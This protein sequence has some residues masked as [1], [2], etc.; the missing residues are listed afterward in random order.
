MELCK[1]LW[2]VNEIVPI[3]E[4]IRGN[5]NITHPFSAHPARKRFFENLDP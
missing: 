3:E 2:A 5:K 4:A 1:K